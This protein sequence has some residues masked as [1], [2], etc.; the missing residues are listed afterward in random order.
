LYGV[1]DL[2]PGKA[3]P[4]REKGHKSESLLKTLAFVFLLKL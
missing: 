4:E 2:A 3:Q 1:L